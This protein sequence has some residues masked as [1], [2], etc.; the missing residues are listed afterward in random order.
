MKNGFENLYYKTTG[1]QKT[2][3]HPEDFFPGGFPVNNEPGP[4]N[5]L[6]P[7]KKSNP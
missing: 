5:F 6:L 2:H 3:I 4:E 1:Y 7:M